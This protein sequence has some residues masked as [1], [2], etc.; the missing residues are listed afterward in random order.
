MTK[1]TFINMKEL[2]NNIQ[3]YSGEEMDLF[4]H[5]MEKRDGTKRIS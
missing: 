5:R 3:H 1:L 4:G 2:G